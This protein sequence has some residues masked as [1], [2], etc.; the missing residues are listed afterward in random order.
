[1]G[2][3][4]ININYTRRNLREKENLKELDLRK[5]RVLKNDRLKTGLCG[6]H[7]IN[8]LQCRDKL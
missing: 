5:N 2:R 3:I 1:M 4:R 8:S 6:V 7:W